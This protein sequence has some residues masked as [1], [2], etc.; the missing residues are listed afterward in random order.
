MP[1]SKSSVMDHTGEKGDVVLQP[2]TR[3]NFGHKLDADEAFFAVNGAPAD[4]ALDK[5]TSKRLLRK[6]DL[7][8]LPV[9]TCHHVRNEIH[10]GI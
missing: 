2:D 6:I 10:L 5:A 1:T 4:S 9:S 7:I 3:Q 8:L